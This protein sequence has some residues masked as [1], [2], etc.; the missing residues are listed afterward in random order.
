[1]CLLKCKKT[2]DYLEAFFDYRYANAVLDDSRF[3]FE[4]YP[5]E[6]KHLANEIYADS[7][8]KMFKAEEIMLAAR[9][10][11]ENAP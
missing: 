1:M 2:L 9:E 8:R 7:Y 4:D 6:V 11:M 10:E 5:D 3:D